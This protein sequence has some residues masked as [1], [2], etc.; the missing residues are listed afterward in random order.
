MCA[1]CYMWSPKVGKSVKSERLEEICS[2]C[3]TCSACSIRSAC[4]PC[5]H[6]S[7]EQRAAISRTLPTFLTFGLPDFPQKS[8]LRTHVFSAETHSF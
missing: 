7:A 3:S 6:R 5:T 8:Y 2:T 1:I 4:F